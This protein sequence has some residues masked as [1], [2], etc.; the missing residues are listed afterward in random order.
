VAVGPAR[1]ARGLTR[2]LV[3]GASGQI[4]GALCRVLP[5][6]IGTYRTRPAPGLRQLDASD[7]DA[8]RRMLDKTGAHVVF[9]P[10]AQ[11]NVD[12]CEAHPA[13]AE[14]GNLGPLR[15]AL[16]A[17]IERDAFLVAYSS[18]YVFDGARGPYVETDPVSPI[19]VYGRIK[20]RLEE[21]TLA[22][23]AAVVRT[24]VVFGSERGEPRNFVLRLVQSLARNETV[25]VPTDQVGTPTY[26]DDVA[27]ASGM[28]A[29][30]RAT[31]IWHVAGPDRIS[32]L[33]L[34]RH[35]ARAFGLSE[36]LIQG[37][38]T[39]ALGQLARR[40]LESGLVIDKLRERFGIT[41]HSVGAALADLR[42]IIDRHE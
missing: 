28:I 25:R 15:V 17:A 40:P 37:V 33:E 29:D 10:A 24:T 34:A 13:E 27:R 36:M 32:R 5:D 30:A 39:S 9:F 2:A 26:S 20:V 11:P 21:E 14:S 38:P 6:T 35:A 7:A 16:A 22:A 23:G 4:G 12:W 19:S 41:M 18:D 8:F 1:L 3:V 42:A 31:G